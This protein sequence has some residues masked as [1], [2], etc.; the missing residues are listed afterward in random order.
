MGGRASDALGD[1]VP[2]TEREFAADA[3]CLGY[4]FIPANEISRALG[5]DHR[6]DPGAGTLV[7]ARAPR[8]GRTSIERVWVVG[9]AG[10]INGAYVAT[11]LGA[12]SG[13]DVVADLGA[14]ALR[15]TRPGDVPP[16]KDTPPSQAFPGTPPQSPI[17]PSP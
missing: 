6:Y 8:P 16:A 9:D 2:G 11:A 15:T 7:A 3:V 10:G 5:C 12:I 1:P 13:A 17:A 14:T 4:G